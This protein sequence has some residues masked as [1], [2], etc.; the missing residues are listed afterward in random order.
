MRESVIEFLFINHPLDCPICDQGGECDLQDETLQFGSDRSRFYEF[1]RSVEDKEVGPI[2]KTIMTRCIHCT[3]C[4]R[5]NS[6][7]SGAD[8]FGTLNRGTATE[9]GSYKLS[10]YKSE[11]SGNVIDLCPVG[12]LTSSPYSF[13]ARPW[14]LRSVESID[15]SDGVGSNVYVS[16]KESEIARVFPKI[17]HELNESFISDKARFYFDANKNNRLLNPKIYFSLQ[18]SD[19]QYSYEPW[20]YNENLDY[21]DRRVETLYY[22]TDLILSKI[23][24]ELDIETPK[25]LFLT[26]SATDFDSLFL[27]KN[28]NNTLLKTNNSCIQFKSKHVDSTFLRSNYF[29]NSLSNNVLDIEYSGRVCFLMSSNIRVESS[30][31]NMKL[32]IKYAQNNYNAFGFFSNFISSFELEFINLDLNKVLSFFE[33]KSKTSQYIIKFKNPLFVFSNH[34][35]SRRGLYYNFFNKFIKEIIPNSLILKIDNAPNSNGG[36]FLGN[37]SL[38]LK[39]LSKANVLVFVDF[40]DSYSLRKH[41]N[42]FIHNNKVKKKIIWINSH[43]SYLINDFSK[44]N[45]VNVSLIPT[46]TEYEEEKAYINLEERIQKTSRIFSTL[47]KKGIFSTKVIIANLFSFVEKNK[48]YNRYFNFYKEILSNPELF[49]KLKQAKFLNLSISKILLKYSYFILSSYPLKLDNEDF[50]LNNKMLKN[51]KVMQI[52]SQSTRKESTNFY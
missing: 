39:M 43:N 1:K 23:F 21:Y 17:N 12:A 37:S 5:F 27:S 19:N 50:Y 32:R 46:N 29:I 51:S 35:L 33:A 8:F 4:V 16:F 34:L 41:L 47:T 20:S 3:R 14:E 45:L 30:I 40:D 18:I 31:V 6:E 22:Y 42:H 44:L 28:L 25:I 48:N 13:K 11:L 7:I 38:S 9:I 36:L 2:I 10:S 52:C 49:K 26:N 15:L 24:I